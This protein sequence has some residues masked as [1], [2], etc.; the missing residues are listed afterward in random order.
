MKPTIKPA[1]TFLQKYGIEI[2]LVFIG[3]LLVFL[4]L[5]FRL[6]SLTYGLA[7]PIEA[8]SR[9]AAASWHA[10]IDNPLNAPYTVIQRL[11]ILTGHNGVT[12]MRLVSTLWAVFAMVLF[13]IVARQWHSMKVATLATWLFISSSWFLHTARLATPEILWLV[14]ILALVV[15]FSPKRDYSE[16]WATFPILVGMLSATIYIPAMIWLVL[17]SIVLRKDN[18]ADAWHASSN[19]LVRAGGI[20][21]GILML[22]P[23]GYAFYK[24]QGLLR[25][26]AGLTTSFDAPVIMIKQFLSVPK[27]LF[28][29]G[30]FDPVHWLGRVPLLSVFET[31]MFILGAYFYMRH[32]KAARAKFIV[33]LSLLAWIIIGIGGVA[34]LSLIVPVV[35]LIVATGI[36][37][38]LH[39]WLKVFPQ[40]P[41][42]R[43]IGI[44]IIAIA[45]L[46]TS[47]YQTRSYF[48]A[49]RYS[50]DTAKVFTEKL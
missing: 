23:L 27:Q 40:N 12:S 20:L 24:N 1:Q 9:T 22:S 49:W 25:E 6:G 45:I 8:E 15:I 3:F 18:I 38:M 30:P 33:I 10:I 44:A 35:Y 47:I 11:V 32:L 29:S 36:A 43:V 34:S 13:Y 42:A 39:E 2:L 41:I 28:I 16:N 31:V 7:A 50:P 19:F 17:L 26:W 4:L 46:L 21:L 14:G 48:V 5:W 37:Y